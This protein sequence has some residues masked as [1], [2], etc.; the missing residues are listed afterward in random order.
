MELR[1]FLQ[2]IPNSVSGDG[3][4]FVATLKKMLDY[5][6]K[7]LDKMSVNTEQ[8]SNVTLTE[9]NRLVDNVRFNDIRVSWSIAGIEDYSKAAVWYMTDG[10]WQKDGESEGDN[11]EYVIQ[12]AE[13][14]KTYYVK[15][16]AI[17]SK[18][19]AS[20]IDD[21]PMAT[22]VVTCNPYTPNAPTQF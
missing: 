8:V 4:S 15:V 1:D 20:S 17:N 16:V 3:K 11:H 5:L 9:V 14:G 18:G 10:E 22:I 13:T 19:T 7:E 21:A 6:L 12:G 2:L